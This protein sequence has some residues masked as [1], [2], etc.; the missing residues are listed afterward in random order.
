MFRHPNYYKN[1]RK[2]AR[3]SELHVRPISGSEASDTDQ[4]I[5]PTRATAPSRRATGPGPKQQA[6]DETVPHCDIEE[7][8]SSK[9]QAS[10]TKLVQVPDA[11]VKP[12]AQRVK[13]QATSVKL[14]DS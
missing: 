4:A 2:L 11:S 7:A 12:Q 5:S 13:R 3:N 8:T 6:I 9:P 1:L 10:S 14:P